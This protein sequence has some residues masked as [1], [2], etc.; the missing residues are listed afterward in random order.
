MRI[1]GREKK[2]RMGIDGTA[3]LPRNPIR[4]YHA[5]AQGAPV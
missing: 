3:R 5:A 2:I 1:A 4:D